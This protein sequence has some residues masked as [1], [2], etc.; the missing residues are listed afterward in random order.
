MDDEVFDS[1]SS[2]QSVL[3]YMLWEKKLLKGLET[4][5]VGS[6]TFETFCQSSITNCKACVQTSFWKIHIYGARVYFTSKS[7]WTTMI[8]LQ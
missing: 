1:R 8:Y 2:K 3:K 5:L 6:L 7:R 4:G